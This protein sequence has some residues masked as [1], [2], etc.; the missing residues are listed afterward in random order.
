MIQPRGPGRPRIPNARAK[1][2]DAAERHLGQSEGLKIELLEVAAEAGVS[3]PTAYRLFPGGR[4]EV[5]AATI[6]RRAASFNQAM[7]EHLAGFDEPLELF[8]ESLLYVIRE[9]PKHPVL[10]R[11]LTANLLESVSGGGSEEVSSLAP[12]LVL[13][14]VYR[15]MVPRVS[16]E[17]LDVLSDLARRIGLSA[18]VLG[19]HDELRRGGEAARAKLRAWLG[20][21]VREQLAQTS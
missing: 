20:P 9:L 5:I 7:L 18:F 11:A 19:D 15:R 3:R 12:G 6:A 13:R 17:Q 2:L 1:V 16:D 21:V 14:S 4:D 8:V 10:E